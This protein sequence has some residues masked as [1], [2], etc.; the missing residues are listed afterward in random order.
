MK[1]TNP[2]SGLRDAAKDAINGKKPKSEVDYRAGTPGE[3]CG[4][5]EYFEVRGKNQCLKVA[6]GISASMVCDL[7]EKDED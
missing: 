3:R 1:Y 6:G 4:E 5:C 2:S 7:F